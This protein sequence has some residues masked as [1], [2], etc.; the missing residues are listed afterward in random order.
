MSGACRSNEKYWRL[1]IPAFGRSFGAPMV[2]WTISMPEN[3]SLALAARSDSCCRRALH[4]IHSVVDRMQRSAR[5]FDR[6][7]RNRPLHGTTGMHGA[8][9]AAR[10]KQPGQEAHLYPPCDQTAVSEDYSRSARLRLDKTKPGNPTGRS[11][12]RGCNQPTNP[13]AIRGQA[14]PASFGQT[15]PTT[16]TAEEECSHAAYVLPSEQI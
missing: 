14:W 9:D 7:G 4:G 2:D 13:S 10:N 3:G 8:A 1:W 12:G 15:E 16:L 5:P 6:F 11:I